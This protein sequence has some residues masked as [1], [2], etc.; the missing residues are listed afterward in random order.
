MDDGKWV[1]IRGHRVFIKNTNDYMNDKIRRNKESKTN[2]EKMPKIIEEE[3]NHGDFNQCVM[4]MNDKDGNTIAYLKYLKLNDMK[5][6]EVWNTFF[7]GKRFAIQMIEV[8]EK[9]RRKKYATALLKKLQSKYPKEEIRF[10]QLEPD[11]EKLLN[12]IANISSTE[13]RPGH[14]RLTYYGTIK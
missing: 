14:D 2:K 13:L 5:K 10:G 3:H 8:D 7:G 4:Y 11:G 9:Y 6:K 12:S 1:T